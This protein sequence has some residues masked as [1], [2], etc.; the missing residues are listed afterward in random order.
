V[1]RS[2][3]ALCKLQQAR[4]RTLKEPLKLF[5]KFRDELGA[6]VGKVEWMAAAVQFV[7]TEG[8]FPCPDEIL[9]WVWVW[10]H[11]VSTATNEQIVKRGN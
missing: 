7:A 11:V 1:P 8:M 4:E 10:D 6:D 9:V 3:E 2:W 5:H